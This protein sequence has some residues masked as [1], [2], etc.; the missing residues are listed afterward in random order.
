MMLVLS[1]HMSPHSAKR[2]S[3]IN[4]KIF[5]FHYGCQTLDLFTD[6][7][8]MRAVLEAAAT[9]QKLQISVTIGVETSK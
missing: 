4:L 2:Q 6:D 9:V 1:G 7:K 3:W 8:Q 5:I